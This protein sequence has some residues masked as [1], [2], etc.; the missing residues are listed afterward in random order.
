M[1]PAVGLDVDDFTFHCLSFA[2]DS[3]NMTTAAQTVPSKT[4]KAIK[5]ISEE[6]EYAEVVYPPHLRVFSEESKAEDEDEGNYTGGTT[7]GITGGAT[8]SD[9]G[10]SNAREFL[11]VDLPTD[12]PAIQEVPGYYK[13]LRREDVGVSSYYKLTVRE[14][15]TQ[16]RHGK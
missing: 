10:F 12:L 15:A 3:P 16:P 9:S 8:G 2:A 13:S 5:I 11:K 6:S 4:A 1:T 14:T 7:A